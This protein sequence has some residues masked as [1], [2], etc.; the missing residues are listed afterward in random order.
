MKKEIVEILS[1]KPFIPHPAFKNPHAQTI[2]SSLLPRRTPRLNRQSEPRFFDVGPQVRVLAHCSWQR[3]RASHPTLLILHGLEGSTE[4]PYML[5]IAEKALAAGFNAIR[6][7]HRNCGGTEDLAPTL[8]HAGLTDDIR[9]II[10]ELIEKDRLTELYLA[11]FSL[12]GNIVLKLAGEL[13]GDAPAALKKVAAISPSL[14]LLSC[15]DAI[16]MRSNIIYHRRFLK[17][18][19]TRMSRM[20]RLYPHLYDASRLR[21]ISTIR[22]FDDLYTA[23]H[24]GFLDVTDYYRRASALPSI[25]GIAIPTL[26]IHSKDDPFIPFAPFESQEIASNPNVALVATDRGGHVGFIA[27]MVESGDRFWAET[28][29]IEFLLLP[30]P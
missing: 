17:S 5:G 18:L 20:A 13:G 6:I 29:A 10:S 19:R 15:A 22:Q 16:E 7:N 8:Y 2:V 24:A 23:P 4:S 30:L 11:G 3:D 28:R 25:K 27:A 14:D 21:R 1:R 26:I 9:H 12:G